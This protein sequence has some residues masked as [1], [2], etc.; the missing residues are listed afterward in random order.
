MSRVSL[1]FSA[2]WVVLAVVIAAVMVL[3]LSLALG[4]PAAHAAS[5][6]PE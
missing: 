5:S 6:T 2:R 4:V 3:A 1:P